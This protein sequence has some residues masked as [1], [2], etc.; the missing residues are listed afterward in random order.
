MGAGEYVYEDVDVE[1]HDGVG[2]IVPIWHVNASHRS[3]GVADARLASTP[4]KPIPATPS[5]ASSSR[6]RM[7][8]LPVGVPTAPTPIY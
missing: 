2:E 6:A 5:V 4:P 3:D 1:V 8:D 7:E